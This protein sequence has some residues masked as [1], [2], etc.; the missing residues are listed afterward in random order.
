[1]I[2]EETKQVL[3]QKT[4]CHGQAVAPVYGV[5]CFWWYIRNSFQ[6]P[7]LLLPSL[8]LPYWC[9]LSYRSLFG[10]GFCYRTILIGGILVEISHAI[11]FVIALRKLNVEKTAMTMLMCISSILFFVETF[12][13]LVVVTAFRPSLSNNLRRST[14]NIEIDTNNDDEPLRSYHHNP[15]ISNI[16]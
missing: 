9:Y 8:F 11:V 14:N 6:P 2:D 4:W 3:I 16:L 5:I 7:A 12:A 15:T 10:N 1:M 13:F